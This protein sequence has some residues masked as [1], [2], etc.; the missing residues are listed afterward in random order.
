[1]A[2]FI[3]ILII[4]IAIVGIEQMEYQSANPPAGKGV[5]HISFDSFLE[6]YENYPSRFTLFKETVYYSRPQTID[7]AEVNVRFSFSYFDW[8][9]YCKWYAKKMSEQERREFEAIQKT[10]NEEFA[11]SKRR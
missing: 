9:L 8:K 3:L 6:L 11:R 7:K 5:F 2:L 1:M 10:Y 4:G